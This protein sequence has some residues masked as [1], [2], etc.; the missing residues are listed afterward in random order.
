MGLYQI[1]GKD[2]LY[3]WLSKEPDPSCRLLMLEWLA[4]IAEDP[5]RDAYRVPG[6]LAPVYLAVTPVRNV[7]MTFLFIEQFHTVA[8]KEFG[9]LP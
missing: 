2:V 4:R 8:I 7:T 9:T 5:I 3:D 6:I 1:S